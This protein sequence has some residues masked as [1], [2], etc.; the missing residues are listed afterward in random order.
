MIRPIV[1]YGHP[2]LRKKARPVQDWAQ[3]RTLVDDMLETMH[4]AR[5]IGLAAPQVNELVQVFVIDTAQLADG[6]DDDYP[7]GEPICQPF[8]NPEIL[9]RSDETNVY[10]EG[11]LSI[12][13]VRANVTRPARVRIRYQDLDGQVHEQEFTGLTARAIQHEYDHL[14]G[15]LFIDYLS[16]LKRQ[17]IKGRLR[18]IQQGRVRVPY[19]VLRGR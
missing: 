9:E 2:A 14:L 11:C 19:P 8:I 4:N 7:L 1:L 6:Y 5:G 10:E 17:M 15:K 12:P 18:D 16:P 13:D 3:V